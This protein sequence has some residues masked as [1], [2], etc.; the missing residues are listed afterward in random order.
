MKKQLVRKKIVYRKIQD[1]KPH[2]KQEIYND[3]PTEQKIL[4][5]AE[6]MAKDGQLQPIE[7]TTAN[8]IICGNT[9]ITAANKLGWT[10]IACWIRDDLENEGEDAVERRLLEDNLYRKQLNPLHMAIIYKRLRELKGS[11]PDDVHG[12]LR[13]VLAKQFGVSG[14][15]LD[16]RSKLLEAPPIVQKLVMAKKLTQGAGCQ[17]AGFSAEVQ[18]EIVTRISNGE[19]PRSVIAEYVEQRRLERSRTHDVLARFFNIIKLCEQ[20]VATQLEEV[21]PAQWKHE[22]PTLLTAGELITMLHNHIANGGM[23]GDEV[24]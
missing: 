16:R 11:R 2:P 20:V 21:Y 5:L 3:P 7:I 13:D 14:R 23:P 9:R 17:V 22:L 10:E 4:E 19:A 15:S 24:I 6:S 12:D 18:E 8:I 1:L